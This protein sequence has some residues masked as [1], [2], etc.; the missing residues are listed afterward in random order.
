[1]NNILKNKKIK[2]YSLSIV[3]MSVLF[4]GVFMQSC[5]DGKT[6]VYAKTC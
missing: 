4:A 1:M 3:V 2:V 5:S 6:N